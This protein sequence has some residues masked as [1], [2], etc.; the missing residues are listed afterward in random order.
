MWSRKTTNT[1]KV[2]IIGRPNVGKSTLFN[3]LTRT[4]KSVVKDEAGVTRDIQIE[5]TEWWGKKFDV[6]DT[7]GLTDAK[8]EFSVLIKEN[9]LSLIDDFDSLV[10]VM[11]GRSGLLPEDR[12]LVRLANESGKPYLLVVNKVDQ[13][14]KSEMILS[15]FYEFGR[16]VIA[17]SFERRDNVD[18]IVEW[19]IENV[20]EPKHTEREGLRVAIVGKPNVGKSSLCN[21]LLGKKRMLVSDIAGTTVD[22]IEDCFSYNEKQ[23]IIVDT[24]GLRRQAKRNDGVEFLSAIKSHKAIDQA[25]L[26][27]LMVDGQEGPTKQDAHVVEYILSKHKAVIMVANKV[28]LAKK[29]IPAFRKWFKETTEKEFHFF[30]DIPIAFTCANTGTGVNQLLDQVIHTWDRLNIKIPTS[31]LNKFFYNVIRQAPSPVYATK[32][33]KFY[34]LTQTDQVPPSFIAFANQPDGVTP[35]Y[36]RFLSNRIKKNWDLMG[37]PVRIFVMKSGR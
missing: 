33:V 35:S 16:E 22:A 18:E 17:C 14:H 29:K 9:L 2:A 36:R 21:Y 3:I 31:Q 34:Y 6:V 13:M 15:E 20:E 5:P 19:I 32:N 27:L 1:P 8:D 26:V 37:L 28:D 24:A 4:R 7:G 23:F 12:L 11:D 30:T 10:V 25:D